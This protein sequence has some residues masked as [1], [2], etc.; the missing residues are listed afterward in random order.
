[1][2]CQRIA[3]ESGDLGVGHALEEVVI[4]VELPNMGRA[5]PHILGVGIGV[6]PACCSGAGG[7]MEARFA[8]PGPIAT[9]GRFMGGSARTR[10]LLQTTHLARCDPDRIEV[11]RV[12]FHGSNYGLAP[13]LKQES[14]W[15]FAFK[16]TKLH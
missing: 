16:L 14:M 11:F 6:R 10:R 4:A 3:L 12:Q 9:S 13:D 1:M 8:A 15:R 2:T 5:E 7:P